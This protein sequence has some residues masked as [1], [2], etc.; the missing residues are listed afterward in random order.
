[1]VEHEFAVGAG[2]AEAGIAAGGLDLL[3]LLEQGGCLFLAEEFLGL[4]GGEERQDIVDALDALV[5][6]GDEFL[7]LGLL[8][9][10][11]DRSAANSVSMLGFS[12]R[13]K[14]SS[15]AS[16]TSVWH[17]PKPCA[18][19]IPISA[20]PIVAMVV[21]ELPVMTDTTAQIMQVDTRKK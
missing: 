16:P 7:G 10:L 13:L 6:C 9:R 11:A 3:A 12:S 17:S 14:A 2:R 21:H 20:M 5:Q 19:P 1:M 15:T 4:V 18:F 8:I